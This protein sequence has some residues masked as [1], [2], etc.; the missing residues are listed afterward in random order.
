M[1]ADEMLEARKFSLTPEQREA[2]STVG[3]TPFLDGEYTVFGE[4]VSGM[5]VVEA[6][7]KTATDS[8][9]RPVNDVR[10]LE[11]NIVSYK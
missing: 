9:D 6:I 8:N 2:Y 1:K 11:M 5:E 3:G 4:V 7:E 10:I